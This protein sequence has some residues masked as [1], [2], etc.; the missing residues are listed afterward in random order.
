MAESFLV[1]IVASTFGVFF[2][3]MGSL[4]LYPPFAKWH[5]KFTNSMQGVPTKITPLSMKA[6]AWSGIFLITLGSLFISV[7]LIFLN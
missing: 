7:V 3:V 6:R 1:K 5:I 4:L 2:V